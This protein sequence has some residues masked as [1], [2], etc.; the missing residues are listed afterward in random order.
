MPKKMPKYSEIF[1]VSATKSSLLLLSFTTVV[2]VLKITTNQV[3]RHFL[4]IPKYFFHGI[5]DRSYF[6]I[7]Y[8][9]YIYGRTPDKRQIVLQHCSDISFFFIIWGHWKPVLS[10]SISICGTGMEY[11]L[12]SVKNPDPV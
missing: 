3:Y 12:C 5:S 2:I 10:T 8:R 9:I 1:L 7:N 11:Y 4:E 6:K